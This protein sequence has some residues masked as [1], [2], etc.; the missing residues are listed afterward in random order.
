MMMINEMRCAA[1]NHN[2]MYHIYAE[3]FSYLN[4]N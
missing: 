4:F 3:E 1:D 2:Y